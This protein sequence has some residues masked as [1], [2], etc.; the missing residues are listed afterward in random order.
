MKDLFHWIGRRV[1][2]RGSKR[3]GRV[4]RINEIY[5]TIEINGISNAAT[6]HY[7]ELILLKPKAKQERIVWVHKAVFSVS[8]VV[9][10]GIYDKSEGPEYVRCTLKLNDKQKEK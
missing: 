5:V 3:K 9:G 10:S 4:V 7:E 1:R 6:Y 8:Y 2:V